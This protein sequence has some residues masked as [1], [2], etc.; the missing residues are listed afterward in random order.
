MD[1]TTLPKHHALLITASNRAEAAERIYNEL[2]QQSPAHTF[3]NQTVLDIETAR[4]IISWANTPYNEEKFAVISF[5]TA[6]LEAQ[7]T[8]LKILEEPRNGIRF[9]LVTSNKENLIAT[10]LSRVVCVEENNNKESL[11]EATKFLETSH[12]LRMK[13]PYV[14]DILSRTDEEDRKDRESVREFILALASVLNENSVSLNYVEE[15]L[16]S[17]SYAADPSASGKALLE[18]L[19]LLLPQTKA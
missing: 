4:K 10:V 3:F 8:L 16:Q 14:V 17:A 18:Y 6:G 5:H 19:S 7:N 12:A 1:I 11:Y 15:T 2:K 13:L 9:I